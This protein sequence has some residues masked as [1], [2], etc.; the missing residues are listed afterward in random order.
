MY[1]QV[2]LLISKL[3]NERSAKYYGLTSAQKADYDSR[4]AS[5]TKL[6]S[7]ILARATAVRNG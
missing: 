3:K 7:D 1:D 6:K 5:A 4:I 2:I